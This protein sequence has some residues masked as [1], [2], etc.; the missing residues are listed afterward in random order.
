MVAACPGG[1]PGPPVPGSG[2][3]SAVRPRPS[4]TD[5]QRATTVKEAHV[6]ELMS[7]P[8]VFGVGVGAADDNPAEPVVVI[9]VEPGK[10]HRPIPPQ[11]NGVRTKVISTDRFRAYGWNE[12]GVQQACSVR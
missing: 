2:A 10:P 12:H 4:D 8:A 5:V 11:L 7:D 3:F 6:E 1:F 9:Y